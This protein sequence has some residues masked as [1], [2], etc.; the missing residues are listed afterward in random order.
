M[1][2]SS[3]PALCSSV[4]FVIL[5]QISCGLKFTCLLGVQGPTLEPRTWLLTF[6][7]TKRRLDP[8]GRS[9]DLMSTS[10]IYDTFLRLRVFQSS[11]GG[12]L[13]FEACISFGTFGSWAPYEK[14]V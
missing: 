11:P 8:E 12:L 9:R 4:V 2:F 5:P 1:C 3:V 6:A 7:L 13:L 10:L 14:E